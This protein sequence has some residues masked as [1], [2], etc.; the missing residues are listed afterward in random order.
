M[1]ALLLFT[2]ILALPAEASAEPS[3]T[4]SFYDGSGR[5]AGQSFT[6]GNS[7]S[8]SDERGRFS[9]SAV[10]NRNGT[11]SFYDGRGRFTGSS[12]S[13]GSR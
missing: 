5:F 12:V 13:T 1:R 10:R 9:G 7:T 2:A 4:R 8:L 6:R 11:T 3:S